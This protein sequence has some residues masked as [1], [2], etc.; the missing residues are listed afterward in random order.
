[1][2]GATWVY[3]DP[4]FYH[5]NIC[6]FV[7]YDGSPLRPWDCAK[8]MTEQMIEWYN[9]LVDDRDRVYILLNKQDRIFM[10]KIV[11]HGE[12][13]PSNVI[14]PAPGTFNGWETWGGFTIDTALAQ[15]G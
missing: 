7:N 11:M 13:L 2:S 14:Q 1:M 5:D 15:T 6:K 10:F 9:E 3:S 12:G 4:H 8:E